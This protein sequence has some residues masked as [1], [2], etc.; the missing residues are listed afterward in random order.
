[1]LSNAT[2]KQELNSICKKPRG[3]FLSAGLFIYLPITD[4]IEE[5]RSVFNKS[6]L[7][8]LSFLIALEKGT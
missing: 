3:Y 8:G 5:I 6:R 7:I 2:S 4:Q 1:M